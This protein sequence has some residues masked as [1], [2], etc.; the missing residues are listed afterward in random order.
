M[1]QTGPLYPWP[2]AFLETA[3]VPQTVSTGAE[4][5]GMLLGPTG[6]ATC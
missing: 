5:A 3:S 1:V 4:E 6:R 2:G